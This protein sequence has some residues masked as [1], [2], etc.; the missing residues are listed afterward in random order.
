M[1]VS[2][3]LIYAYFDDKASLL[4]EL[5]SVGAR[6]L[7]ASLD[8]AV[9]AADTGDELPCLCREY[10]AHMREHAWL[11]VSDGNAAAL[12]LPDDAHMTVFIQR[13]APLLGSVTADDP[14]TRRALHLWIG[15]Q[16]L[17]AIVHRGHH[18]VD[19]P[20]VAS[21]LRMLARTVREPVQPVSVAPL[22][23]LGDAV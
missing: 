14:A 21:H 17:F 8:E 16:G 12:E 2:T 1:G 3:A 19:E 6:Q 5:R 10:L 18:A 23:A 13:A 15:L 9:A 7:A 20:L 11:Y 22:H 4:D